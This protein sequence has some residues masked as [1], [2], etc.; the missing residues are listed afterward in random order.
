MFVLQEG[1]EPDAAHT[2]YS[3]INNKSKMVS[4][5]EYGANVGYI[6]VSALAGGYGFYDIYFQDDIISSL[7]NEISFYDLTG[8]SILHFVP[9]MSYIVEYQNNGFSTY[10]EAVMSH[11]VS[12]MEI[13]IDDTSVLQESIE[14]ILA[15][16]DGKASQIASGQTLSSFSVASEHSLQHAYKGDF[17]PVYDTDNGITYYGGHQNW[18]EEDSYKSNGCGPVAAANITYY[19]AQQSSLS[20]P[21][22]DYSN[23]YINF[24]ITKS[25]FLE[26]MNEM[27][28]AC[29]P[30]I[31]GDFSLAEW[32]DDVLNYANGCGVSLTATEV[33]VAPLE[34]C[35]QCVANGLD[36]DSPVAVLNLALPFGA[37]SEYNWHWMTITRLFESAGILSVWVSTWGE[38]REIEF[39][40]LWQKIFYWGG[41]FCYF[42]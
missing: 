39:S 13:T 7:L 31:F 32:R 22:K 2:I 37:D 24:D 12:F 23:L 3:P 15:H 33:T 35:Q 10:Y 28:A 17:V 41:G 20:R 4:I 25:T 18:Y 19:L 40:I 21:G 29:S 9:P 42:Y 30:G 36:L 11:G 27:Y 38:Q 16:S 6:T 1:C 14:S 5:M 8:E 34:E 26:H